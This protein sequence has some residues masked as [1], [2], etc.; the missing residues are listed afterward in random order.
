M[1][2][3]RAKFEAVLSQLTLA[4]NGVIALENSA[5]D[6]DASHPFETEFTGVHQTLENVRTW[7][8][9]KILEA[10][11]EA[12]M[13]GFLSELKVV[14]DKYA[15]KMEVGSDES[16]YGESYGTGGTV[17]VKFTATL[18]GVTATKEI[19]KAIIVSGDLI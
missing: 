9:Q 3:D 2:I 11:Q 14:F 16:G 8:N 19:N 7:A 10:D 15:A 5:H 6:A 12:V 4:E 13:N 17:G 18:D 1:T